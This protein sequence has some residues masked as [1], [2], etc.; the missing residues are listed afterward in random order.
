M[1]KSLFFPTLCLLFMLTSCVQEDLAFHQ[2]DLIG[3]YAGHFS[4][5]NPTSG[6]SGLTIFSGKAPNEFIIS[7]VDKVNGLEA[8][9]VDL[10][11]FP[12]T[13]HDCEFIGNQRVSGLFDLTIIGEVADDNISF[14]LQGTVMGEERNCSFEG[15]R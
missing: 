10:A 2:P 11:P 9:L 14:T 6:K 7:S 3:N 5:I 4:C 13:L 8:E 15:Q 12:V 1:T